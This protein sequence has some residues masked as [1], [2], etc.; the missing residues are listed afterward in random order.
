M[1]FGGFRYIVHIIVKEEI[2][3]PESIIYFKS[4]DF[5]QNFYIDIPLNLL[6]IENIRNDLKNYRNIDDAVHDLDY[7]SKDTQILFNVLSMINI[8]SFLLESF[9]DFNPNYWI[10]DLMQVVVQDGVIVEETKTQTLNED[11]ELYSD[12]YGYDDYPILYGNYELAKQ[13]YKR[14]K[15][16]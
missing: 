5:N 2:K 10:E 16:E 4:F 14:N 13:L 15:V 12:F 11:G 6:T 7:L 9:T 8:K 3:I 1:T